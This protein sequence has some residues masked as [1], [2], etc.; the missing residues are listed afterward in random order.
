MKNSRTR[1]NFE[2]IL[3]S[4]LFKSQNFITIKLMSYDLIQNMS[5]SFAVDE[6]THSQ[7]FI[8]SLVQRVFFQRCFSSYLRGSCF[9]EF[10][11]ALSGRQG[12][13]DLCLLDYCPLRFLMY[14][15]FVGIHLFMQYIQTKNKHF[16]NR[17]KTIK[18]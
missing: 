13:P 7:Q 17:I 8:D 9:Q 10:N 12:E 18:I 16:C 2:N 1:K 15:I 5:I 3:H 11:I 14:F 4:K 6:N